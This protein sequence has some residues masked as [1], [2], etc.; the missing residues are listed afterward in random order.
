MGNT[1]HL[2]IAFVY[3]W[4]FSNNYLR[5]LSADFTELLTFEV[6][7]FNASRSIRVGVSGRYPLIP[8]IGLS[9]LQSLGFHLSFYGSVPNL[10]S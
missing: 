3:D 10:F 9:V 6:S 7:L 5:L 1:I 4:Y 2:W 8:P